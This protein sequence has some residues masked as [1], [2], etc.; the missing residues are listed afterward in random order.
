MEN[1][2][3]NMEKLLPTI[4]N[5]NDAINSDEVQNIMKGGANNDYPKSDINKYDSYKTESEKTNFL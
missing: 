2:S 3:D 4:E 5:I 1:I